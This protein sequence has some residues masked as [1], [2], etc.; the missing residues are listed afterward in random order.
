MR[1]IDF[2]LSY[3]KTECTEGEKALIRTALDDNFYNAPPIDAK[4]ILFNLHNKCKHKYI[5]EKLGA[6][7]VIKYIKDVTAWGLKESKDWFDKYIKIETYAN[8]EA[9]ET[10][11]GY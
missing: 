3:I 1:T 8:N 6:L 7:N 9:S 5:V 2:I 10:A 4:S 11:T